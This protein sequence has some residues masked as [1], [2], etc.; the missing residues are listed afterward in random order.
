MYLILV[1]SRYLMGN[2]IGFMSFMEFCCQW[3]RLNGSFI[4]SW[5]QV[6]TWPFRVHPWRLRS[7]HPCKWYRDVRGNTAWTWRVHVGLVLKTCWALPSSYF[8]TFRFGPIWT[9]F[10]RYHGEFFYCF[11]LWRVCSFLHIICHLEK[12]LGELL[13]CDHLGVADVGNGA[14]GAGLFKAWDN[15]CATIMTFSEEEL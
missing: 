8:M 6:G 2:C 3:K 13:N 5:Y 14:W 12:Y 10:L 1:H 7:L 15:S 4:A 11:L 9:H